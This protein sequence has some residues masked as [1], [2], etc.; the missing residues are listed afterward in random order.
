MAIFCSPLSRVHPTTDLQTQHVSAPDCVEVHPI[1]REPRLRTSGSTRAPPRASSR[2][3]DQVRRP[4]L[5]TAHS[6]ALPR[7]RVMAS[8]FHVVRNPVGLP[9]SCAPLL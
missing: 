3:R 6:R 1:A 4:A 2:D 5:G 9:S 8:S 7:R